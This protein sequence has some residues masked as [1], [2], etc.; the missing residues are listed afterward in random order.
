[1]T[2]LRYSS[3]SGSFFLKGSLYIPVDLVENEGKACCRNN[4]QSDSFFALSSLCTDSILLPSGDSVDF[5]C[6]LP[7]RQWARLRH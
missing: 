5:H 3:F 4:L 2:I 7:P 1:M 6:P